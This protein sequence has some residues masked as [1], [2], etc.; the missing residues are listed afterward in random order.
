MLDGIHPE[1]AHAGIPQRYQVIG[2]DVLHLLAFG[3][4]IPHGAQAAFLNFPLVAVVGNV[5]GAAMEVGGGDAVW[6][7]LGGEARIGSGGAVVITAGHALLFSGCDVGTGGLIDYDIGDDVYA[8]GVALL[9]HVLEFGLGA[10]FGIKSVAHRLVTRPPLCALNGFLRRRHFHICHAFRSI[11][12]G[13][14]LGNRVP[15]LLE[16]DDL[17]I[18]LRARPRFRLGLGHCRHHKRGTRHG[19]GDANRHHPANRSI[20]DGHN[21][22]FSSSRSANGFLSRTPSSDNVCVICTRR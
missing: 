7:L 5:L 12:V 6:I 18:L 14:F 10:E 3:V 4:E 21:S 20:L 1:R 9:D 16:G 2:L 22:P 15:A 17:H 13:A 8:G 19:H 11:G